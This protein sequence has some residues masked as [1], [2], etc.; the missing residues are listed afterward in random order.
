MIDKEANNKLI[1]LKSFVVPGY[2]N[3]NIKVPWLIIAYVSKPQF[4]ARCA[5][6]SF[7]A[8]MF[9]CTFSQ[10]GLHRFKFSVLTGVLRVSWD[11]P[12][13]L[14]SSQVCCARLIK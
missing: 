8:N 6:T 5:R 10:T 1:T 7:Y 2:I 11:W 3:G 12:L 4:S 14:R 9:H 13:P